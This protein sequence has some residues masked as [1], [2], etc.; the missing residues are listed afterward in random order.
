MKLI[1]LFLIP[2]S[3]SVKPEKFLSGHS[4]PVQSAIVNH[5][6]TTLFS[7]DMKGLLHIFFYLKDGISTS[8]NKPVRQKDLRAILAGS[9][10]VLYEFLFVTRRLIRRRPALGKLAVTV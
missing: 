8:S 4:S 7:Y 10:I 2:K 1:S 3:S 5:R 6:G 9:E